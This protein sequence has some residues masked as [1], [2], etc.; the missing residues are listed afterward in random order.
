MEDIENNTPLFNIDLP[1]DTH[2]KMIRFDLKDKF[3]AVA[4]KTTVEIFALDGDA[5]TN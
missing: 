3:I 4:S 1:A 5:V 2:I